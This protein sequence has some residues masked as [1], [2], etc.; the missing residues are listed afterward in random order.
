MLTGKEFRIPD[1]RNPE[2]R[3]KVRWDTR[4]P[5]GKTLEEITLP[6]NMADKDQFDLYDPKYRFQL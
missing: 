3:D 6:F 1:F 5:F 4:T 2:D